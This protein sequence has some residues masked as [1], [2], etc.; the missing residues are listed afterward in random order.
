MNENNEFNNNQQ[1]ENYDQFKP[2]T[3]TSPLNNEEVSEQLEHSTVQENGVI[4]QIIHTF[5]H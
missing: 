5:A 3:H 2:T 1:P 4:K